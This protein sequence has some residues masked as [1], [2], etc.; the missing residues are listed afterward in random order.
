[1]VNFNY[2]TLEYIQ[3]Q[4]HSILGFIIITNFIIIFIM[5]FS[6]CVNKKI[7]LFFNEIQ[8]KSVLIIIAHPDDE[9]MFFSPTIKNLLNKKINIKLLCLSNG[10]Y[11]GIG[12]IREEEFSKVCKQLKIEDY[13]ILND[14]RLQDNIKLKWD[15][16]YVKSK[17]AHYMNDHNNLDEIGA[18]ISFDEIG[19]TSHSNHISCCEGLM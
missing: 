14:D 9:I 6:I 10:N 12:K 18:I 5:K 16:E 17:I 2:D 11:D 3:S 8:K 13:K 4:I 15:K 7:N 19:V 1:M